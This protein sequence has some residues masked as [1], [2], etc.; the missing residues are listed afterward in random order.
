VPTTDSSATEAPDGDD[1]DT[2]ASSTEGPEV[3]SGVV[4]ISDDLGDVEVDAPATV[5]V[6]TSDEA[7]EMVVAL[8]LEPVGVASTRVDASVRDDDRFADYFIGAE[9]LGTPEFVGADSL[10][11]ES[12]AALDPD[13]IVHA[14]ADDNVETL[15]E[16]A[17]TAVFD[18]QMPGRWQ[19]ALVEVGTAT[20]RSDAAADLIAAYD[21]LLVDARSQLEAIA[22]GAPELTV[23]Y[24]NYRGGD[25]NFVFDADFALASVVPDL[26]FDLVGIDAA[27]PAFPGVGTI[28]TERY[29]DLAA[30]TDTIIAVGPDDWATTASGPFLESLSV[31]V[32]SLQ[33]DE[34][35]PSTGPLSAPVYLQRFL[36]ALTAH[37]GDSVASGGAEAVEALG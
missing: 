6:T 4:T 32:L 25:D 1:P 9:A 16:I 21:A 26:G 5:I 37:Y 24:P 12:I 31:P 18:I 19:D 29:E 3:V 23:I 10:N 22:A 35:R 34:G 11:F 30:G 33:V 27:E 15:R 14:A 7:T 28:S 13:F 20:G 17:P 8:G 36:D 2:S